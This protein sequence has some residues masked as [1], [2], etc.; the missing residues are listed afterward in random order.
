VNGS[1]NKIPIFFVMGIATTVGAP[2]KLLSSEALQRLDPCSLILG[3]PSDRMNALVEAI[4]AKP[5][6]GFWISHEVA[7]F[8]RNYF[9]RR[10]G[11]ITSFTSALKLACSKH[12]YQAV[13]PFSPK[14]KE[15][16]TRH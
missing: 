7:V 10:D 14:L 4:L 15:R 13:L 16:H 6:A 1:F 5:C 9:M 12:F 11:T 8:L 2:R 3:S